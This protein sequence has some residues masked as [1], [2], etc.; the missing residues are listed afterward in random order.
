MLQYHEVLQNEQNNTIVHIAILSNNYT[1]EICHLQ[2]FISPI[3]TQVTIKLLTVLLAIYQTRDTVFQ[4]ISNTEKRVENTM[5]SGV[6]LTN[7]EVFDIVM[8]H[9]DECLI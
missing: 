4:H 2:S 5:R 1:C 6:F 9:Y 3:I 8:K 7:F